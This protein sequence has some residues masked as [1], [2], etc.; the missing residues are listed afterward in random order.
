MTVTCQLLSA[1]VD[2]HENSQKFD[3]LRRELISLALKDSDGDSKSYRF[4]E[5]NIQ[6]KLH[7]FRGTTVT[8]LRA[9]D[10]TPQPKSDTVAFA[11]HGEPNVGVRVPGNASIA[12][13]T[14]AIEAMET[15][16]GKFHWAS[17]SR[18][19][20]FWVDLTNQLRS[21]AGLPPVQY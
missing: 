20:K 3:A 5:Y 19:R 14:A 15:L 18:G 1:L 11:Y 7:P 4:G 13:Q 6:V 16:S 21:V 8:V 9:Q 12:E 17:S 2:A 10:L